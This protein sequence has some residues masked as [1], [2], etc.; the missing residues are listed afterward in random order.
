M[1]FREL[2]EGIPEMEVSSVVAVIGAAIAGYALL[3][4][5]A[6]LLFWWVDRRQDG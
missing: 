2:F 4:I 1:T 5:V 6:L 3:Q